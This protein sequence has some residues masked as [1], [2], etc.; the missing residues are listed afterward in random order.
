VVHHNCKL[1]SLR[2][3]RNES[4]IDMNDAGLLINAGNVSDESRHKC[5]MYKRQHYNNAENR[6]I[7]TAAIEGRARIRQRRSMITHVYYT[8]SDE[9]VFFRDDNMRKAIFGAT[10]ESYFF[11]GRRCEKYYD[12]KSGPEQHDVFVPGRY[13]G[14]PGFQLQ[15]PA[16][17]Y[18]HI[19]Q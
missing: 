12:P 17:N 8:E 5:T 7:A 4:H 11:M 19:L 18:I 15:W 10:N 3:R 9:I 6:K 16:N 14:K 1:S 13:C 2:H